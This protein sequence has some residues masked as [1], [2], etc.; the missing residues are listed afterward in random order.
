MH[1]DRRVLS[2]SQYMRGGGPLRCNGQACP[3]LQQHAAVCPQSCLCQLLLHTHHDAL[4]NVGSTSLQHSTTQ[5]GTAQHSTR[6][7]PLLA[8]P[9]N[10]RPLQYTHISQQLHNQRIVT[11]SQHTNPACTNTSLLNHTTTTNATPVTAAPF[12][13]SIIH[14]Y[15]AH[16]VDGLPLRLCARPTARLAPLVNVRQVTPPASEGG[17]PALVPAATHNILCVCVCTQAAQR[18]TY[19]KK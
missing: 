19:N 8:L 6:H 11:A 1:S 16:C 3:H 12:L 17:H 10:A 18:T 7:T 14:Y 4:D 5:H 15:L 13:S 2:H 9:Y